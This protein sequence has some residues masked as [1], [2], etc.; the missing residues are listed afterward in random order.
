MELTDKVREEGGI[1][2]MLWFNIQQMHELDEIKKLTGQSNSLIVRVAISEYLK[3]I[4][5]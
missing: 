3:Q 5:G 2:K 1:R 4:K